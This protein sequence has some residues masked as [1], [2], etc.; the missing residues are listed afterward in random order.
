MV[1]WHSAGAPEGVR[2]VP[3][4][5]RDKIGARACRQRLRTRPRLRCPEWRLLGDVGDAEP[6]DAIVESRAAAVVEPIR[7]LARELASGQ[8]K[9]TA[10]FF[11][12]RYV[13]PVLA[14]HQ[15]AWGLL[16]I[17]AFCL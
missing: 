13:L 14:Y 16:A 11:L 4:C 8:R 12:H 17:I 9:G 7:C 3:I 2:G 15:G 10:V 1:T 5:C 6:F